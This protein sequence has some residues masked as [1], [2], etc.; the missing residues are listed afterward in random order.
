MDGNNFSSSIFLPFFFLISCPGGRQRSVVQI[1]LPKVAAPSL[2]GPLANATIALEED[3]I[4]PIN[5]SVGVREAREVKAN[6][7]EYR[8]RETSTLTSNTSSSS[9]SSQ[10]KLLTPSHLPSIREPGEGTWSL[11]PGH[12]YLQGPQQGYS[13]KT[14]ERSSTT[15]A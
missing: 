3:T 2:Q 9:P 10:A 14:N 13:G 8:K 4:A 12:Q 15:S 6:I 7:K 1:N 11:L 5:I